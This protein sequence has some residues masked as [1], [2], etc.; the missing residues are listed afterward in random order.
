MKFDVIVGNPPYQLSDGGFGR[1]AS[2]IYQRFVTQAKKLEPRHLVM[3]IPS[4][5]FGGGKGLDDFREE[6]LSD[7]RI[8]TMHDFED[9]SDVFPGVSVAG[10]ICY[11][12]WD[13]DYHG[14]C[15]MVNM[16]GDK[17]SSTVRKLD[18]FDTFIRES[19]AVPIIRCSRG[20]K[21]YRPAP[22]ALKH[23]W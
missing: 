7:D 9:A 6:M 4:R 14:D 21:C 5:W 19:Q 11:F 15:E 3:I 10:G 12:V 16:H 13:R 1:S 2:P 8:R 23:I 20:R 18:E 17:R 22:S